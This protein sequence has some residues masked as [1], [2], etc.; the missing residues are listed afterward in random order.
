MVNIFQV[1]SSNSKRY[2]L[3]DL[4]S[5]R[6]FST[7]KLVSE[8]FLVESLARMYKDCVRNNEASAQIKCKTV[9]NR[10]EVF[11]ILVVESDHIKV[12]GLHSSA[13]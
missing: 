13:Q 3:Y 4:E 2:K 10:V 9:T 11:F 6:F 7:S 1:R 8:A 12:G 5:I